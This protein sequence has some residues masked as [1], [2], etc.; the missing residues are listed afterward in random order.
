M[1]AVLS[2]SSHSVELALNLGAFLSKE[3][4][5]CP[6]DILLAEYKSKFNFKLRYLK[7]KVDVPVHKKNASNFLRGTAALTISVAVKI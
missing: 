6:N 2:N 4:K 1:L 7:K 5:K 3:N